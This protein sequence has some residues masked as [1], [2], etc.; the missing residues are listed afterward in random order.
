MTA[1]DSQILKKIKN[2]ITRIDPMAVAILFGS[3]ATGKAG[4]DS[5]WDILILLNKS[6]ISLKDEQQFRHNLYDIELETGELIS[7]L[8]Y[9]S[10]DWNT[11]LSV[12]PIYQAVKK[13]GI[14]L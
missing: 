12:T 13:H 2:T 7:T 3:R 4:K 9:S 1:S 14:V 5:D 11:K 8:I 10:E 6:K